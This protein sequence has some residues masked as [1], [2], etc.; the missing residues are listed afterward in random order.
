MRLFR[1]KN[2]GE[3]TEYKEQDFRDEHREQTLESWLESNPDSI[4]E[5]GSL[6]II[7]R[8]VST[9]L[10]SF[11]DLLALD[12]SGSTVVLEL[13]RD[14][15]PRET[16]AQALEYA[17]FVETLDY[18]Q[19]ELILR[20]YTGTEGENL[21]EYHRAFFGL[22][23]S[24]SVSFNKD[25]RIVIVGSDITPEIR[26]TATFLRRK[27]LRV[28]C[29]EFKYFQTESGE[30]LLSSDIVVGREGG[31]KPGD[32]TTQRLPPIDKEKFLESLN[33]AGRPFFEAVLGLSE[34]HN[35]PIHWGSKGFSLNVD[36]KGKH[37]NL[38]FGYPPK[39]VFK[40]SLYTAF[41]FIK[42]QMGGAEDLVT[43]FRNKFER[44]G[45]FIPA[46]SEVKL[47]IQQRMTEKQI[48]EV[49]EL[50]EDLANSVKELGLAETDEA[51]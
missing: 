50:L 44:T 9:N 45:I 46:G 30:T 21:S 18:E 11:I 3:F 34:S 51:R 42:R 4:I 29:S 10:R 25:Q 24:E 43:S 47:V 40:Q 35:L 15:T 22:D 27:G 26:Q 17:S 6:L 12:R 28:T 20:K 49:V 5:D 2:S 39:S 8:Q 13:K 1:I 36:I 23:E 41:A 38:C 48:N 37:V 33:Q 32:I 31:G 14:Y 19:L 7:G 16:I